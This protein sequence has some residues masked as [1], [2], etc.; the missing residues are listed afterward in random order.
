MWSSAECS[1]TEFDNSVGKVKGLFV[2]CMLCVCVFTDVTMLTNVH[3]ACDAKSKSQFLKEA[4]SVFT[5]GSK[6][7]V[8]AHEITGR[9]LTT[10]QH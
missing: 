10:L 3:L 8:C 4:A 7:G 1:N 9:T 6:Q 2:W 5:P